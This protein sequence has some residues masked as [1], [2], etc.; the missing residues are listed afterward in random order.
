ME[1][2][3][4]VNSFDLI[5]DTMLNN[6]LVGDYGQDVIGDPEHSMEN[7]HQQSHED[8]C[9]VVAQEFILDEIT[10]RDFTEEE[11]R[12]EATQSGWYSDGGGTPINDV[13]NLL[14]AHGIEVEKTTGNT[15]EDL[16]EKLE[17]G[18]K[19]IVGVNAE[20]IWNSGAENHMANEPFESLWGSDDNNPNHAVEVIGID[21]SDSDNPMVILNDPGHSEGMGMEVPVSDF[22]DAWADSDE[23][24]VNTTGNVETN[25][26]LD[27]LNSKDSNVDTSDPSLGGFYNKDG[28]YHWS[29]DNTNTDEHGNIVSYGI[30]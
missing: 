22:M 11:L 5:N 3:F 29:S 21:N 9:A 12:Q 18:N 16:K 27:S 4:L 24:M 14:E 13:G 2:G 19:I 17:D 7:W 23:F 6:D 28:T 8:T 1:D 26:D 15:L 30:N 20:D 25:S 10:G